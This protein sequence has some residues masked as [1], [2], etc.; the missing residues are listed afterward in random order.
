MSNPILTEQQTRD[1]LILRQLHQLQ[2]K[3][4]YHFVT[5]QFYQ[6]AFSNSIARRI[7][8]HGGNR[9]GKNNIAEWRTL[10]IM[11][12]MDPYNKAFG[13]E[14]PIYGRWCGV[15]MKEQVLK[16]IVAWFKKLTPRKWFKSG[17]WE[18]NSQ[19]NLIQFA[20]DGPCKGGWIEL[21]SYDQDPNKGTGRPLHFV[22]FDEAY[23]CS[24]GFRQVALSRLYDYH[25]FAWALETPEEGDATWSPQWVDRSGTRSVYMYD[26][27]TKITSEDEA[28]KSIEI[29]VDDA[30]DGDY[31]T[32]CFPTRLNKW[33]YK[34][35]EY[36]KGS[37]AIAQIEK[38]AEDAPNPDNELRI[39]LN[40]E[41]I[42]IG[43]VI[44][45][46]LDAKIHVMTSDKFRV[47]NTW[48]K[49][50]NVDPGK[51]KE[52]ALVWCAVG[53]GKRVYFYR[54]LYI[55]GTM[56]EMMI[57]ARKVMGT[58]RIQALNFDPHWNYEDQ[59]VKARDGKTAFNLQT[60]LR[61]A[62]DETGFSHI[63]L[64]PA[65]IRTRESAFDVIR[66]KLRP[67]QLT[68][69]PDIAFSPECT[70]LWSEMKGYRYARDKAKDPIRYKPKVR[71]I[72]DDGP[73]CVRIAITS[74]VEYLGLT[75]VIHV[76]SHVEV[77]EY[78]FAW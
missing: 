38:D 21:M 39:R 12:G 24:V 16:V 15:G 30:K 64:I 49:Y 43:G 53:P 31:A 4:G 72:D 7:V 65:E 13:W 19:T 14:P 2:R 6:E 67:H 32:F 52:H 62:M 37:P 77:D 55:S 8:L 78:G 66:V 34:D 74:G 9:S 50:L 58:E 59:T 25:G 60:D 73:D 45:P 47:D 40:G 27:L 70:R 20:D 69:V 17:D 1:A 68:G 56:D 5:P 61:Q 54:E 35:K 28:K 36:A 75:G 76:P 33:L 11:C 23:A 71:E 44:Y 26:A 10:R 42:S 22:V 46:V 3:E 29:R 51:N 57:E 63:D 18:F 41:F 48:T